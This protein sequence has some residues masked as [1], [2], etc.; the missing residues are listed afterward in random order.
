[1]LLFDCNT[2]HGSN[3]NITPNPRS[4][5]FFVY[6]AWSN[7]VEAPFA[8]KAPRP[9]FLSARDPKGPIDIVSGKLG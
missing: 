3:G 9:A 1:M 2:I 4:N 5:A 6:N 8:A 7:K